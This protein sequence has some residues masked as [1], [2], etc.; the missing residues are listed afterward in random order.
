MTTLAFVWR[1]L[2]FVEIHGGYAFPFSVV[3]RIK[4]E[5]RRD[6]RTSGHTVDWS[7]PDGDGF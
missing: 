7:R 3:K 6:V 2:S 4:G 1:L 5:A